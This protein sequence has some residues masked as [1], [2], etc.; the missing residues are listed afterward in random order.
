MSCTEVDR[1]L[2]K[3]VPYG[4]GGERVGR[5]KADGSEEIITRGGEDTSDMTKCG[6]IQCCT[7]WLT[8]VLGRGRPT[9]VKTWSLVWRGYTRD[10]EVMSSAVFRRGIEDYFKNGTPEFKNGVFNS[11]GDLHFQLALS[12]ILTHH[13]PVYEAHHFLWSFQDLRV[14]RRVSQRQE[15]GVCDLE[16]CLPLLYKD[17]CK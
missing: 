16:H 1:K 3:L 5:K 9:K 10:D 7:K 4:V 15:D 11:T 13:V 6:R 8:I 2:T 14:Q 12:W 17:A